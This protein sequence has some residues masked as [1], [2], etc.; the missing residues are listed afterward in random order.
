[1]SLSHC[2]LGSGPRYMICVTLFCTLRESKNLR[3]FENR[4]RFSHGRRFFGSRSVQTRATKSDASGHCLLLL[5]DPWPGEEAVTSSS[6]ALDW[7]NQRG[8]AWQAL[9]SVPR[10]A[11]C[12][13]ALAC[14]LL[15][16]WQSGS[17]V[18]SGR[19]NISSS[20]HTAQPTWTVQAPPPGLAVAAFYALDESVPVSSPHLWR[21]SSC[22]APTSLLDWPRR[23]RN[24]LENV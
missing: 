10:L 24:K 17:A 6:A 21:H 5:P 8:R 3:P 1:M 9:G 12:S 11:Q 15:V 22:Q 14:R 18:C 23:R 20:C 19:T 13:G 16:D 2:C 7:E 4:V